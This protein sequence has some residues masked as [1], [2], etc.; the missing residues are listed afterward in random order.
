MLRR[1]LV[2]EGLAT[3]PRAAAVGVLGLALLAGCAS[4]PGHPETVSFDAPA[5]VQETAPL[6]G[7]G[8]ALRKRDLRR[9][10]RDMSHYHVTLESLHARKDRSG[11]IMF[12]RYL[13]AYM[14]THLSPML[15]AQWQ[16][17]HP[18]LM[19]LDA[20]LRL[21]QADVLVRM[22]ETRRA[23]ATIDELRRRFAGRESLLVEYPIG[24]QTTLDKALRSLEERKWRG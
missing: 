11:L 19:A 13:D 5:E 1:N 8:L 21:A 12:N 22:H 15:Q 20:N 3:L 10:H 23:Q 7:E 2:T 6:G 9:A 14:H 4:G 17:R 18:E 16:S 24:D